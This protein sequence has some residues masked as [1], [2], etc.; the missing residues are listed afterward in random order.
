MSQ[1][2]DGSNK[3]LYEFRDELSPFQLIVERCF[4]V[5]VTAAILK[6]PNNPFVLRRFGRHHVECGQPALSRRRS[7]T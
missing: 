7:G 5:A 6:R 3:Q 2:V 4:Q 1:K